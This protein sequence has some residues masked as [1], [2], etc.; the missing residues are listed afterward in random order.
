MDSVYSSFHLHY[1]S[2]VYHYCCLWLQINEN[3]LFSLLPNIP[4][5]LLCTLQF[6]VFTVP[7][8]QLQAISYMEVR[9][10]FVCVKGWVCPIFLLPLKSP[11]VKETKKPWSCL[12]V[13]TS[14][15]QRQPSRYLLRIL[16]IS[17]LLQLWAA[18]GIS[19]PCFGYLRPWLSWDSK[20]S[21]ASRGHDFLSR[22]DSCL[23]EKKKALLPNHTYLKI[24]CRLTV[25]SFISVTHQ[26][27][28]SF[29]PALPHS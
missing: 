6:P 15:F 7:T 23:K 14:E 10:K 18:S 29:D 20:D 11:H 16:G 1:V 3:Y 13:S 28:D 9:R 25:S 17:E 12:L 22:I 4:Y 2:E 24:K 26:Y 8:A 19:R 27:H 5:D 21:R